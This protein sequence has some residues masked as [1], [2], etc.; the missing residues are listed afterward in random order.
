MSML[1]GMPWVGWALGEGLAWLKAGL[2]L[3]AFLSLWHITPL[4]PLHSESK[5]EASESEL[6]PC[7]R[8]H[9]TQALSRLPDRV[10]TPDTPILL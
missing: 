9:L 4:A 1:P 6:E 10:H 8:A 5:L 3:P 2:V 7:V